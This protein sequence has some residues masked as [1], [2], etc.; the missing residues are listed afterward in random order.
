[1]SRTDTAHRVADRLE[2]ARDLLAE[3]GGRAREGAGIA[4]ERMADVAEAVEPG[5]RRVSATVAG[6]ARTALSSLSFLPAVLSQVLTLLAG[7]TGG[8]AERGREVAAR[9]EP[10]ASVKRR[11]R[12]RTLLWFLGGFGAGTATGWVL[13]ARMQ[14][15]PAPADLAPEGSDRPYGEAAAPIDARRESA[16]LG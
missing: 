11:S 16:G 2:P 4:R 15:H 1:M 8:L 3:A 7:L 9:I 13:H 5:A 14:E 6:G 12:L 10:P